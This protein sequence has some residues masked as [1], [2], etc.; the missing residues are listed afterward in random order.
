MYGR[1]LSANYRASPFSNTSI[2]LFFCSSSSFTLAILLFYFTPL[3]TEREHPF[4]YT[5]QIQG[6]CLGE[7]RVY[8]RELYRI[9]P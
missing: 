6:L 8:W 9:H 5:H 1:L 2:A 3:F 7:L 4:Y